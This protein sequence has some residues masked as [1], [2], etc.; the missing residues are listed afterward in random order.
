M[1]C[2]VFYFGDCSTDICLLY[3]IVFVHLCYVFF[4]YKFQVQQLYD[5]ICGPIKSI[6][7]VC[8]DGRMDAGM[9]PAVI[10]EFEVHTV[11]QTWH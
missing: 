2:K 9:N 4:F 7:C 8:V 6:M 5:R 11:H 10:E 3:C 1:L